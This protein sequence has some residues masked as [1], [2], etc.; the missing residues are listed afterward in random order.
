MAI[1][2]EVCREYS[3]ERIN[4]VCNHPDV[5]PWLGG[6][7]GA[8]DLSATIADQRNVLLMGEGGGLLF[9]C[10]RPGQYEVHTQFLPDARGENAVKVTRDALRYMFTRTDAAEILT[11]VPECNKGAKGLVRAINGT[12]R[13]RRESAWIAPDGT[14]CAVDYY[15]L[16]IQDWAGKC[17]EVEASGDWFH[18]KL[19]AAKAERG[20]SEPLH[21]HDEAHDRYVGATVEMVLAGQAPKAVDF[22]NSWASFSGYGPVSVI[23]VNPILF[24]IGDA[25]LAVRHDDFE[26]LLCR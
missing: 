4:V 13:F 26:V 3:A 5:R 18:G 17:A 2:L 6:G 10:L 14:P 7:T 24:D 1:A 20:A 15:A 25:V 22:Y 19:E 16:T 11:K 21:D 8:L 23:A 12:K 9:V